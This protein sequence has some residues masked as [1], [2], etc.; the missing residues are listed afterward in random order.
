MVLEKFS[1]LAAATLARPKIHATTSKTEIFF[2]SRPPQYGFEHQCSIPLQYVPTVFG[3]LIKRIPP[4]PSMPAII[5]QLPAKRPAQL[6][7]SGGVSVSYRN[8]KK[9]EKLP[10]FIIS[11]VVPM[12]VSSSSITI[13]IM[14][15][16]RP[17]TTAKRYKNCH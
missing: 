7:S 14:I 10:S 6:Q 8:N 15:M 3:N 16:I 2:I 9:P 12:M 5:S 1:T 17:V 4:C 13:M 11:P